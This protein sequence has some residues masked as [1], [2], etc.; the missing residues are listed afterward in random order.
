MIDS[1]PALLGYSFPPGIIPFVT[2]HYD[3]VYGDP[4][5]FHKFLF[6]FVD[7]AGNHRQRGEALLD[8][9]LS[10]PVSEISMTNMDSN[11]L[12]VS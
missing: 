8:R 3:M 10:A 11:V 12:K 7:T 4:L 5:A 9:D 2:C 6:H 1:Y